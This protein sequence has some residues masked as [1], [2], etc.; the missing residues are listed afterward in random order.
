MGLDSCLCRVRCQS[1][2]VEESR[3]VSPYTAS[4]LHSKTDQGGREL[5]LTFLPHAVMLLLIST[6]LGVSGSPECHPQMTKTTS[7]ALYGAVHCT[8]CEEGE[9]GRQSQ[10]IV[11]VQPYYWLHHGQY[12][13]HPPTHWPQFECHFLW[14]PFLTITDLYSGKNHPSPSQHPSKL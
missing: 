2:E 8:H 9:G 1:L 4:L 10:H 12:F 6:V 3:T 5:P 7:S 13:S 11:G 14:E